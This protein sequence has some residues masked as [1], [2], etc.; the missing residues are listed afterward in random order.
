MKTVELTESNATL[1][2][3]G[4]ESTRSMDIKQVTVKKWPASGESLKLIVLDEKDIPIYSQ[5]L[6]PSQAPEDNIITIDKRF[7]FYDHLSVQLEA[8]AS[9]FSVIIH[10]E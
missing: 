4:S 6:E 9:P 1:R 3:E 7:V 2:L 10:F 8:N 5:L